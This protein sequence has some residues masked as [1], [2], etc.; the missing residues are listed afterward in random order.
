MKP[1]AW[2]ATLAI[3]L[4]SMGCF[5]LQHELPANAYFG[6]LPGG[7]APPGIPFDRTARKNWALSGLIPYS[8]WSTSDLL[9]AEPSVPTAG[10]VQIR[11]IETVFAPF[12]V[13]ITIFPGSFYGYYFWATRTIHVSGVAQAAER[14]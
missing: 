3:A 8:R 1:F 2:I 6:T 7:A 14:K 13:A 11:E 5:S 12:D 4:G 10:S 9:A